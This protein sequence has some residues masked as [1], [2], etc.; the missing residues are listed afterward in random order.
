MHKNNRA[1]RHP[2]FSILGPGIVYAGA[3]VGVSHLVQ[4]TR[5]GATYGLAMTLII[6][7]SCLIKYPALRFGN[8]YAAATGESLIDSY[9]RQGRWAI[10][11]YG[12]AV[13]TSMFFI[14]G[15]V[16]LTTAGLI[17]YALGLG[18][19]DV[20]LTAG[21]LTACCVLL[22]TGHYHLLER[23][24]KSLV[25]LF[26]LIIIVAVFLTLKKVDWGTFSI[27]PAKLDT[28]TIMFIVALAGFMPTPLDAAAITSLWTCAKA[29][30]TGYRPTPV[31]SRLDFN[32]GY[33]ISIVLALCFMLLGTGVMYASDVTMAKS[34]GEFGGQVIHLFT[35]AI[36]NWAF[37]FISTAAIAVMLSSLFA[38][39]DGLPRSLGT[40]IAYSPLNN[41]RQDGEKGLI[42]YYEAL[43]II[44]AAGAGATVYLLMSSF[45][46][47]IDLVTTIAFLVASPLAFLNHRAMLSRELPHHARPSA[48]IRSWSLLGILIMGGVTLFYLY[49]RLFS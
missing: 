10:A 28:A 38:I 2:F 14:V 37:P 9:V 15:A 29:R 45:A 25:A 43:V 27:L 44:I 34:A 26:S 42:P 46:T 21:L 5:A 23:V 30:E 7:V 35:Q 40:L 17:K 48:F 31:E 18:I 4:S 3:A 19:G 11:M 12:F 39:M 32:V 41:R 1:V 49:L 36:G 6:I 8:E 16:S 24:N 33:V 47:F 13:I 20:P 22:I